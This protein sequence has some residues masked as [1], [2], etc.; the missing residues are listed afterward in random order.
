MVRAD[1]VIHQAANDWS[2]MSQQPNPH[3]TD[4]VVE[5]ITNDI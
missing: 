3:N 1:G 5:I 2:V 4:R